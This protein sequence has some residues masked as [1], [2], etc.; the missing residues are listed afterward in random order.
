M[1]RLVAEF[2][3]F[4]RADSQDGTPESVDA[5][6][7]SRELVQNAARAGQAVSLGALAAIGE[8]QLRPRPIMR[9]L[10]NL[11]ANATRYGHNARLSLTARPG[12]FSF[13][14]ED[15]GPG[16]APADRAEAMKPF[17][18]LDKARNQDKGGGVGLGL[19]IATDIAR[20]HGG[21]L[22]LGKSQDMGGL[23]AELRLPR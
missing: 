6:A 17:T 11:L 1:Q 4:A 21:Q 7:F 23:K 15:D 12:F 2:L 14:V 13:V 16:I 19:A 10:E 18:R 22:L 5:A 3:N 8:V 9:A 20:A